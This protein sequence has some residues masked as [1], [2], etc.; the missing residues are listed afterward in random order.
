MP[1]LSFFI[2]GKEIKDMV[3]KKYGTV[4]LMEWMC[5]IAV[6]KARFSFHFSGGMFNGYGM[7]PATFTTSDE[8]QQ[9][10]IEHSDYFRSGKIKL[11]SAYGRNDGKKGGVEKDDELTPYPDVRNSQQAKSVLLSA[12]YGVPLSKLGNKESILTAAKECG[13]WF[14]NWT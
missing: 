4:G 7:I 3:T 1:L 9:H 6:G 11:L 14:P 8:F 12:P 2:K 5:S 13:V 10:V